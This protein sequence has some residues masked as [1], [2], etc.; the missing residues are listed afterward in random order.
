LTLE[1]AISH[2]NSR[3][4]NINLQWFVC[5]WNDGYIVHSSSHL[6]RHPDIEYVYCTGDPNLIWM[7]AFDETEKAFKHTVK[8]RKNVNNK[9]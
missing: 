2:A 3:S 4:R 7:I 1:E 6:K 8:K 5:P 9:R